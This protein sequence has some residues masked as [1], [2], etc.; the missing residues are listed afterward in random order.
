[1]FVGFLLKPQFSISDSDDDR[2]GLMTSVIDESRTTH[3]GFESAGDVM[4]S[5]SA[6][7]GFSSVMETSIDSRF[8]G[9]FDV[10]ERAGEQQDEIAPPVLREFSAQDQGRPRPRS[11]AIDRLDE[12]VRFMMQLNGDGLGETE[13]RSRSSASNVIHAADRKSNGQGLTGATRKAKKEDK[14]VSL[15]DVSNGQVVSKSFAEEK[16]QHSVTRKEMKTTANT[17]MSS[18]SR[19]RQEMVISKG[20]VVRI[21]VP[22]GPEGSS[23]V[24]MDR[25]RP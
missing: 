8:G 13:A 21:R 20:D 25:N 22:Y 18:T 19:T 11:E 23:D 1:M 2:S 15:A 6:T 9:G 4:N 10:V 17:F 16:L 12:S 5:S 24:T 14:T 3:Q 7:G